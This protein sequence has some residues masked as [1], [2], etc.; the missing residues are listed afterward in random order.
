MVSKLLF[1]GCWVN[2]ENSEIR[3]TP[4]DFS[5]PINHYCRYLLR[6]TITHLAK[7]VF[8]VRCSDR[9][10]IVRDA[11]VTRRFTDSP[12]FGLTEPRRYHRFCSAWPR[13]GTSSLVKAG[14]RVV[15]HRDRVCGWETAAILRRGNC[16]HLIAAGL[17]PCPRSGFRF[18]SA[19][20]QQ[21][22]IYRYSRP[23]RR[24][25]RRHRSGVQGRSPCGGGVLASDE[26]PERCGLPSDRLVRADDNARRCVGHGRSAASRPCRAMGQ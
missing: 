19:V 14:S 3:N 17:R 6:R 20:G 11:S 4:T 21:A 12:C 2:A 18:A 23:S 7:S 25:I 15:R 13:A 26:E 9:R 5:L 8:A 1:V 24:H 22:T 16:K 10:N